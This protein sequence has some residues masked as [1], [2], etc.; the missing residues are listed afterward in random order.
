[1][2]LTS[3][4][5]RFHVDISDVDRGVYEA[6]EARVAMHPSESL[7]FL[8]TRVLAYLL[9]V[10]EGLAFSKGG[11]SDVESPP[12]S[13]E[14]LTGLRTL[15]I[16]VGTP[17]PERLHKA[18]KAAPAV[19]VYL[20]KP[21]EPWKQQLEGKPIHRR[22]EIEVFSISPALISD[23]GEQIERTNHWTFACSDGDLYVTTPNGA[24]SGSLT[25]HPL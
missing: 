4:I 3:T 24:L 6:V 23:L 22:D 7:P 11:L 20:H 9:N 14:D 1:M 18:A 19:R 10:Q 21:F 16:E 5:Y 2:A 8:I 15:W 17:S 13:V 12:L 25:K